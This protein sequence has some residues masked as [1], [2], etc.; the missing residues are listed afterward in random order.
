MRINRGR[1]GSKEAAASSARITRLCAFGA[2]FGLGV[3][4]ASLA[5]RRHDEREPRV[6]TCAASRPAGGEEASCEGTAGLIRPEPRE[7]SFSATGDGALGLRKARP[8]PGLGERARQTVG[9]IGLFFRPE[10][11]ADFHAL[12][13]RD[14]RQ[15]LDAEFLVIFL[16]QADPGGMK[17]PFGLGTLR[18]DLGE[19]E[20]DRR[21]A[22]V[23]IGARG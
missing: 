9:E 2:G 21:D 8:A 1:S 23:L 15:A 14:E 4:I 12:A 7:A 20:F 3:M 6:V 19:H 17:V 22:H 16:L 13:A 10:E 5:R 11:V 18:R